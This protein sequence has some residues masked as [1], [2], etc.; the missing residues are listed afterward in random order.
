MTLCL[1]RREVRALI[2]LLML[3][4]NRDLVD[5]GGAQYPSEAQV[6]IAQAGSHPLN[7][8]STPPCL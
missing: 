5:F 3:L 6:N 1:V 2:R 4:T 7:D 8:F